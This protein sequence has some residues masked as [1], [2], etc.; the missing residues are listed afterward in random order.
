MKVGVIGVGSM[1]QNHAR[2]LSELGLLEG[3]VDVVPAVA[4]AAGRR[5][6]T[7]ISPT[8]GSCLRVT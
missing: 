6:S 8:T 1:G 4:E 7:G 2:I 3:V 5:F